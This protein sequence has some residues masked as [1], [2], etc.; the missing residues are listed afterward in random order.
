MKT[1]FLLI[2]IS[3]ITLLLFTSCETDMDRDVTGGGGK[4]NAN[5]YGNMKLNTEQNYPDSLMYKPSTESG[6]GFK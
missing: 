2:T 5:T 4:E 6:L 3:Y 1:K